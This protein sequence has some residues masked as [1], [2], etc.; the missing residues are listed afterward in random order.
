MI[1]I[2][3]YEE[4]DFDEVF[5]IIKTKFSLAET[6]NKT[7]P[8]PTFLVYEKLKKSVPK[9][10]L[11]AVKQGTVIGFF[12]GYYLDNINSH[13]KG[14]LTPIAWHG[15]LESEN[16]RLVLSTLIAHMSQHNIKQ[17]TYNLVVLVHAYD[18]ETQ[19]I[20][21]DLG[22]GGMTIDYVRGLE[23]VPVKL[24]PEITIKAVELSDLNRLLPLFRGI[25]DHLMGSPI[26][27]HDDDPYTSIIDDY[28]KQLKEG[29]NG[30]F[31]AWHHDEVIGYIKYTTKTINRQELN[32]GF[33]LGINGA[34]ILPNYRSKGVAEALLNRLIEYT[35]EIGYQHIMTD[36]ESANFSASSF[37]GKYFTV[38]S[39]GFLRHINELK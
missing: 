23:T 24:S 26:F 5:A 30:L 13:P 21:F 6:D 9:D 16:K 10:M 32:D 14:F 12:G 1:K 18:Q 22:Y 15:V 31:M 27:L 11:V 34:Y 35:Q 33:T 8:V 17:K 29:G 37:W 20:L 38:Y 3:C 2:R 7:L 36:C 28:T 19:G 39:L 4:T 25:Q